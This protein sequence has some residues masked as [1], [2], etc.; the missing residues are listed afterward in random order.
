MKSVFSMGFPKVRGLSPRRMRMAKEAAAVHV[1]PLWRQRDRG[2][3]R[4]RVG[5]GCLSKPSDA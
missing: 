1:W 5:R 4:Q 2:Q 3:T